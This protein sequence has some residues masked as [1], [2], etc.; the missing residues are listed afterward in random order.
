MLK[1][2]ILIK[3]QHLILQ[4]LFVHKEFCHY[5]KLFIGIRYFNIDIQS[6]SYNA[7]KFGTSFAERLLYKLDCFVHFLMMSFDW[8]R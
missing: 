7:L 5:Y 1:Y 8:K 6:A 3:Y 2:Q 4:R